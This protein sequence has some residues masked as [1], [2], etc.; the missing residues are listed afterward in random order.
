M[1]LHVCLVKNTDIVLCICPKAYA[2]IFYHIMQQFYLFQT[3][4]GNKADVYV[5]LSNISKTALNEL[6]CVV[7]AQLL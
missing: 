4:N 3:R 2:F 1:H 5:L 6:N 7:K